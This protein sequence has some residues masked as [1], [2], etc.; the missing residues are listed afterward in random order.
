LAGRID[1]SDPGACNN[2]GVL[3]YSKGL[4]VDAADAFLRALAIDPRMRTAARNLEVAAARPG[5][6]DARIAALEARL[7]VNE[8]DADARRERA[9][10]LRLIGRL[11]ESIHQFDA[12][13]AEN[14]DDASALLD[15]GLIEVRTGDLRRA[16]RWFERSVNAKGDDP[17]ARL[18]LAEVLYQRGQNEQALAA[19][20]ELLRLDDEVADAHLL[21]GF[22]LGDMGHHEAALVATRRANALKPSLQML[23]SHLSIDATP[24]LAT[25]DAPESA[26]ALMARYSLGLAFRQR[27]YFDQARQEFLRSIEHDEDPRYAQHAIAELDIL[28]GA[29]DRAR[30]AYETLLVSFPD[31]PRY[32]NELGVALHQGGEVSRAAD[33]YR[34]ALRHNP[35]YA[36]AYNNLGVAL[37]DAGDVDAAREALLRSRELNASQLTAP[38]NLAR[39]YQQQNDPLAALTVARELVAF[40]PDQA[41]GW[42]ALGV[43]LMQLQRP[44]EARDAFVRAVE[45]RNDHAEARYELAHA[46]GVLGDADGALRET[47]RALELA[48]VRIAPRLVISIDVQS[49][50][51]DACGAINLL[52]LKSAA[53][54]SGVRVSAGDVAGFLPESAK[55][56]PTRS[57]ST[58]PAAVDVDTTHTHTRLQ[59]AMRD[60]GTVWQEPPAVDAA[61][62]TLADTLT[63]TRHVENDVGNDIENAADSSVECARVC[64]EADEFAARGVHGE[65][66]DRY[67]QVRITLEPHH[68]TV[69]AA[70]YHVWR[71][72]A[73]GEVRSLCVLERAPDA[74]PLLKTLGSHNSRDVEVLV[75]FARASAAASIATTGQ[76]LGLSNIPSAPGAIVSIAPV[77]VPAHAERARKAI[78]QVLR[79]EVPSAALMH[80][81][82][83]AAMDIHDAGLA[84]ACFRRALAVDPARPS[85]R[86][87]IARLL[88]ARG[89]YLAARLELVAALSSAPGW[90]DAILE[91]TRVHA[92]SNRHTDALHIVT[93]HLV[94]CPTDIEALA[95]LADVLMHLERHDDARVV[96]L[97]ILRHEPEHPTAL[98]ME[99]TL[100]A[101]QSRMRDAAE[102]WR[103]VAK[104]TADPARAVLAQRALAELT[105]PSLRL[106][107]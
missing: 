64:A 84:M 56:P 81:A 34:T 73:L 12:I 31:H 9:R 92:E 41:D 15:R 49:E 103:R 55:R 79:S 4:Y 37:A 48:S 43:I 88:R 90:R 20:D 50:C 13:I 102:R 16:Q 19:L 53:P 35:R 70:Q 106:V 99:G 65:A 85:P 28:A 24:I 68:A 10:L 97:R 46:L 57:L 14:P 3:F 47:E 42:H 30:A 54:L 83:D 51:P 25:V 71:R 91:L 27:G 44:R 61:R 98:W 40:H 93:R 59:P 100:L 8:D 67:R 63:A 17:V 11:T 77:V 95:Q 18:H 72:A 74:L 21:R 69:A 38:L 78:L 52:A 32:W 33:A 23:E 60:D 45:Q 26:D 101:R 105:A 36:L 7:A 2:L 66:Y 62:D 96:V 86:V 5:A 39:W 75:L 82:G 87:A 1:Q 76:P 6:C 104:Q 29:F 80:F 22:V 58:E 89:D 94:N 107:S